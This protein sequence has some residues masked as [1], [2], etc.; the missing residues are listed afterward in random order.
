MDSWPLLGAVPRSGG[1]DFHIWAPARRSVAI[2]VNGRDQA[3]GATEEGL[4]AG[5]IDARPGDEYRVVLDEDRAWPDPCSRLQAHGILGAS[6]VVDLGA[7]AWRDGD[8]PGLTLDELV[9]YEL[10]VGAF[11]A[12]GTFADVADRLPQLRDL[13][14]TAIEVMP[15]A[16]FPG[17]R[18]WGY[19]G[20][21]IFAPHPVYGGPEGFAQLVAAAHDI[22]LGIILDVVYN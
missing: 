2:R 1:A 12:G 15:I 13:G 11:S 17:R 6:S 20:V 19:D 5:T 22:G 14:V 3:L 9:V 10:H 16:T 4:F 21:Y 18:N 8:R 7:F